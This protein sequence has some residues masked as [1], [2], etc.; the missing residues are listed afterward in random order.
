[1]GRKTLVSRLGSEGLVSG[2]GRQDVVIDFGMKEVVQ[3]FEGPAD[4]W[5]LGGDDTKTMYPS[6]G[7]KIAGNASFSFT[8]VA[9]GQLFPKVVNNPPMNKVNARSVEDLE[10]SPSINKDKDLSRS[11]IISKTAVI[12]EKRKDPVT[13]SSWKPETRLDKQDQKNGMPT[14]SKVDQFTC[15]ICLTKYSSRQRKYRCKIKH[16]NAPKSFGC[17]CGRRYDR[18]DNRNLHCL[19]KGC[20]PKDF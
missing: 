12:K 19:K 7:P 6:P 18:P 20:T 8:G 9:K 16:M 10:N 15:D 2:F 11:Q 14:E 1:F 3:G 5:D 4:V 17:S 13:A